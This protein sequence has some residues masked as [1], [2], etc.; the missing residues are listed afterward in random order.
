MY[1]TPLL[2]DKPASNYMS[3][4][5]NILPYDA[6]LLDIALLSVGIMRTN[7][8]ASL[9]NDFTTVKLQALV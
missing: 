6:P 1:V 7:T 8:N 4:M 9:R 2:R 5:S 3:Y